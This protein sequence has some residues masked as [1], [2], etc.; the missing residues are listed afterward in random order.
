VPIRP[1]TASPVVSQTRDGSSGSGTTSVG[2]LR[3]TCP[4]STRSCATSPPE[5]YPF[6]APVAVD[7]DTE[8]LTYLHG[9]VARLPYTDP[10]VGDGGTLAEVGRLLR[11]LHDASSDF[12]PPASAAWARG[13]A[14]PAG[15]A[16]RYWVPLTDPSATRRTGKDR[17]DPRRR[18]RLLFDAYGADTAT[19]NAFA[20]TL[21]EAESVAVGYVLA[22]VSA[23]DAAFVDHWRT[24]GGE[25]QHRRRVDWLE[26]NRSGRLRRA[27]HVAGWTLERGA[28]SDQEAPHPTSCDSMRPGTDVM[29]VRGGRLALLVQETS[30]LLDDQGVHGFPRDAHRV[31]PT[32]MPSYADA[33]N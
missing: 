5:A 14:G 27:H 19:R 31:M 20:E 13:F 30:G 8:T 12:V 16:A 23:G 24:S 25:E 6:P 28:D 9:E 17:G 29:V 26:H 15:G 21:L 33:I 11:R 4:P 18:L 7:G 3:R 1:C 10:W 2:Q 22:R 32:T